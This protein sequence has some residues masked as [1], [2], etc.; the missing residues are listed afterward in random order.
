MNEDEKVL[1][2][3]FAAAALCGIMANPERWKQIADD[4]RTGRKTYEQCSQANATKAYSL[5][6]AMMRERRR[7]HG[8]LPE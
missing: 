1:L 2:D 5:G 8:T 7:V 4:Y 6:M 3:E